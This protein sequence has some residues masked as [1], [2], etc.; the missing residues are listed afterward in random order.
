MCSPTSRTRQPGR[1]RP[2]RRR[3]GDG[4]DAALRALDEP[5][6]D[7]VRAGAGGPGRR[8]PGA[9]LH[10][11]LRAAVRRPPDARHLPR[12]AR[13]RRRADAGEDRP[14]VRRRARPG[15]PHGGRARVRRAA[16]DAVRARSRTRSSTQ[17]PRSRID[18]AEI[19]DAQWVDNGPGWVAVL[20]ESAEA[21]LACGPARWRPRHRRRRPA[22]RGRARGVRGPRVLPEGRRDRRGPGDRQPQRVAG[23]VA[24]PHRPGERA[25]RRAARAPRWAARAGCTS[26]R[27]DD[28]QIWVGGATVT[29]VAGEVEL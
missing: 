11:G 15:A 28:G 4:G 7:D 24:A 14:G 2:R 12:L 19:V 13:G 10:P 1:R 20:L 21:V 16:A 26:R 8:L 17:S 22:S 3:A 5:L 27:D 18:R 6:R 25:V 23:A 29:C 9:D